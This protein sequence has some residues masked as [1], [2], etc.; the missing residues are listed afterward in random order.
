MVPAIAQRPHNPGDHEGAAVTPL[1][2]AGATTRILSSTSASFGPGLIEVVIGTAATPSLAVGA[3]VL[4][5]VT[6]PKAPWPGALA[7]LIQN[8]NSAA[9]GT[10]NV[11]ANPWLWTGIM[12]PP[13]VSG[14]APNYTYA[15]IQTQAKAQVATTGAPFTGITAG[16]M[17]ID[18]V[19]V[20]SSGNAVVTTANGG[21]GLQLNIIMQVATAGTILAGARLILIPITGV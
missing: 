10:A 7:M 18:G 2:A 6:I 9:A 14:T 4:L 19:M 20:N 8:F 3:N 13:A 16:A 21:T 12:L 11:V 1:V 17:S 15:S 5:E